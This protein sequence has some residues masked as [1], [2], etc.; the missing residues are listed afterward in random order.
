MHVCVL[1]LIFVRYE[2]LKNWLD[3]RV[4]EEYQGAAYFGCAALAFVA[5]SVVL[6]PGKILSNLKRNS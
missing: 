2:A 4:P 6:V 3:G 1:L 5:S